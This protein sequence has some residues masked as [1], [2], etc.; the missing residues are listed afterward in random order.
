MAI[1]E[2][3]EIFILRRKCYV[4][5]NST[6]TTDMPVCAVHNPRISAGDYGFD[7]RNVK[8]GS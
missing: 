1:E 3:G 4:P 5:H 2:K 6:L 7:A 8:L